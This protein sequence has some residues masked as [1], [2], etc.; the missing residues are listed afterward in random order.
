MTKE[1]YKQFV[2]KFFKTVRARVFYNQC[3]KCI[4]AAHKCISSGLQGQDTCDGCACLESRDDYF[5][6]KCESKPT[7]IEKHY[8]KKCRYFEEDKDE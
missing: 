3:K 5:V 4:H 2:L 7:Y 6:C 8:T 1:E